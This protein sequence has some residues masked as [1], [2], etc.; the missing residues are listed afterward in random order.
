MKAGKVCQD[1]AYARCREGDRY[2]VAIVSDGHGGNNYFRSD[3]GSR[4]AV[5]AARDAIGE[6]MKNFLKVQSAKKLLETYAPDALMRQLETTILYK[7]RMMIKQDYEQEPFTEDELKVMTVE[8]RKKYDAESDK[9]FTKAYG[10]TLIAVVVYPEHFWFGLHIGDGKCVAQYADGHWDQPIPWDEKC[11][12]NLTTSL[13]DERPLDNFRHCFYRDDFPAAL[14]VG[15]DGIDDCFAND[16]DLYGFYQE[17]VQT[18]RNKKFKE[19]SKEVDAFLPMMSEKG[20][21]D[22]VSMSGILKL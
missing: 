14:F 2:A 16:D 17:V 21:G 8:G 4:F 15:S 22:D 12:L 1:A 9:Y 3:R 6:F 19:A 11:F 10:A 5:K 20:S 13:C 18:F 7:W